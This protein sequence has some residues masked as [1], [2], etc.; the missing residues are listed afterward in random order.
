MS[1]A[2]LLT[3]LVS[4]AGCSKSFDCASFASSGLLKEF[5]VD[6]IRATA[7]ESAPARRTCNL[8]FSRAGKTAASADIFWSTDGGNLPSLAATAVSRGVPRPQ[9]EKSENLTASWKGV[10]DYR[11]LSNQLD[12]EEVLIDV[13]DVA[14]D[15]AFVVWLMPTTLDPKDRRPA[16]DQISAAILKRLR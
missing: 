5:G 1:R 3:C 7:E 2:L 15:R 13:V 9:G 11:R 10:R 8:R 4:T 14:D 16:A 12:G 6:E